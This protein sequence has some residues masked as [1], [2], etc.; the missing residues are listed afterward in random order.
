MPN[1]DHANPNA[2]QKT[3]NESYISQPGIKGILGGSVSLLALLVA[4][5]FALPAG[6]IL[7]FTG[8]FLS[9]V[10]LVV[11]ALQSV[12]YSGQW[13]A[14]REGL[15]IERAKT[16]P[17]LRIAEV[18]AVNF[19]VGKRPVYILTIANDGL[20]AAT[21]VRLHMGVEMDTDKELDWIHDPIVTIPASGKESYFIRSSSWLEQEQLVGFNN[22]VA[23]KVVGYFEYSPV[24]RTDFCYRYVPW[25]EQRPPDVPQFVP[26][27]FDPRLNTTLRIQSAV[28]AIG[29]V[30]AVGVGIEKT[31]PKE[32]NPEDDQ[33]NQG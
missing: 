27:D 12:I 17:R 29:S 24:G 8:G 15:E 30:G 25:D 26:C 33:Q 4:F 5:T 3:N 13:N 18:R 14:M 31:P 6:R 16:N 2:V 32:T 22:A 1:E 7:F 11:I 28:M 23:L 19:E 20:L 9:L 21:G 10:T